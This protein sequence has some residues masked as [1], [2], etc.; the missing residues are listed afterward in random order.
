MSYLPEASAIVAASAVVS[1]KLCYV[2]YVQLRLTFALTNDGQL[3]LHH[4]AFRPSASLH[5]EG[6]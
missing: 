1:Y 4:V 3:V 5:D 6:R 2:M